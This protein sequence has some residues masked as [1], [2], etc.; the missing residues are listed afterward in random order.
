MLLA[1]LAAEATDTAPTDASGNATR[2]VAVPNSAALEGLDV[3]YQWVVLD[4]PA[5]ALGAV[6]SNA[7]RATLGQ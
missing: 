1:I 5:N 2:S 7:G 3:F 6:S 4:Q